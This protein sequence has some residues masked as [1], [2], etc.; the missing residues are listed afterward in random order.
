MQYFKTSYLHNWKWKAKNLA[1][2]YFSEI[3]YWLPMKKKDTK[4][5]LSIDLKNFSQS[6]H[7]SSQLSGFCKSL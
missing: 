3:C 1:N 7:S 2:T 6:T 4:V 5:K